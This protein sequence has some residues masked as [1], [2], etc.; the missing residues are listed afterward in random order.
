MHLKLLMRLWVVA[1]VRRCAFTV[2]T[3]MGW[4]W[5][6][7]RLHTR[8]PLSS[9]RLSFDLTSSTGTRMSLI[10]RLPAS[11]IPVEALVNDRSVWGKFWI[12]ARGLC[13]FNATWAT[14]SPAFSAISSVETYPLHRHWTECRTAHGLEI[15][16]P[17]W[18]NEI[19]TVSFL[20]VTSTNFL[21]HGMFAVSLF[22]SSSD[23]DERPSNT[24]PKDCP[25]VLGLWF[26]LISDL[27]RGRARTAE[28]DVIFV[29]RRRGAEVLRFDAVSTLNLETLNV[30][31][32][33]CYEI[34]RP[35]TTTVY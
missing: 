15:I 13:T 22:R 29:A 2:G 10:E 34:H 14:I 27:L 35:G 18:H 20:S 25:V 12:F 26:V 24:R 4:G 7:K 16:H 5:P 31:L 6:A 28:S 33:I 23:F 17:G 30:V 11:R 19:F 21:P 9:P 8:P 1:G 32:Q 3:N